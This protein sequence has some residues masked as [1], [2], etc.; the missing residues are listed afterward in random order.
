M[1]NPPAI[2]VLIPWCE[3]DE[4]RLTLAANAPA[5]RAHEADVLVLNCGGNSGHLRE[6]IAASETSGVRQLDISA[7][8]FNKAL[9]LNVGLLYSRSDTVLI[10]DADVVLLSDFLEEAKALADGKSF[11]TIERV[12]ESEQT[13]PL[14]SQ[15]P[16]V[17]DN[18]TVTLLTSAAIEF[19]FR[20]GTAVQHQLSRRDMFRNMRAGPGLLL[21]QKCDLLEIQGFNSEL[22]TWGWEDDDVLV[23][24]QYARKLRRIQ[25]GA[26]LHLTHGDDRRVLRTSRN[27]SDQINFIK[28]CRNYNNGLFLGT[29]RSDVAGIADK[30]TEKRTDDL[31]PQPADAVVRCSGGHTPSFLFGPTFCGDENGMLRENSW[32]SSNVPYSIDQLLLAATVERFPLE[33][34][35]VLCV[36]VRS[37]GLA[38]RLSSCSRNVTTVTPERIEPSE[39][40]TCHNV[41]SNKYRAAFREYL[42]L[43]VYD[44][45]IDNNIASY[46][47][48]QRHL[49]T[50]MENYSKLLAPAGRLLT[51]QWG[52]DWSASD[53]C[54]KLSDADLAFLASEYGL[55]V[56]KTGYGV[57]TLKSRTTA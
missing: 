20:D 30:V 9:A 45:I 21:A 17:A 55:C 35:D 25:N 15:P 36:G 41:I 26:A 32:D 24:L 12:Y 39:A 46:A 31:D 18:F 3:R 34:Q 1:S 50:L 53:S 54:W 13:V 27:Q 52:M 5:F 48:C 23:R 33:S 56:T 43:N 38:T 42:P 6:L 28:C 49:K 8:R 19:R 40:G 10:L 11:V 44:I 22:E 14:N 51:T 16:G 4:L 57:Y 37:S 2:S 7:P 47:C 29:Y